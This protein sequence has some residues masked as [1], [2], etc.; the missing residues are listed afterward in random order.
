MKETTAN[1]EH[2][3][4]LAFTGTFYEERKKMMEK[5]FRCTKCNEWKKEKEKVA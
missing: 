1:C 4:K 3:W 2:N 5:S